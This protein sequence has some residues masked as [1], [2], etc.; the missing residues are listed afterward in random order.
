MRIEKNELPGIYEAEMDTCLFE[1]KRKLQSEQ[2]RYNIRTE[3]SIVNDVDRSYFIEVI[4]PDPP[5]EDDYG[6]VVDVSLEDRIDNIRCK[7]L[8]LRAFG[9]LYYNE[10][11]EIKIEGKYLAPDDINESL[12]CIKSLPG[13]VVTNYMKDYLK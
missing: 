1:I 5:D 10:I 6:V 9:E 12:E 2:I 7:V 11:F 3:S 8:V 13:L 4:A